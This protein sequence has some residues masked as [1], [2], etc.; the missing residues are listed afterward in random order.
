MSCKLYKQTIGM[1]A[2]VFASKE[3]K[4]DYENSLA[5]LV[6]EPPVA[7]VVCGAGGFDEYKEIAAKATHLKFLALSENDEGD[8][9]TLRE[10]AEKNGMQLIRGD[11]MDK[12]D[13][14]A[15]FRLKVGQ[16]YFK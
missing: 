13:L 8:A 7:I 9:D 11:F 15:M 2:S 14:K 5:S 3:A 10:L 6:N 16:L 12:K 1:T 4:K